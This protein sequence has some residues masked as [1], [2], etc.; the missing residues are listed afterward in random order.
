[1]ATNI[2][3]G[4]ED[5]PLNQHLGQMAYLDELPRTKCYVAVG[6]NAGALSFSG[7]GT[8]AF[9]PWGSSAAY[10]YAD[11]GGDWDIANKRFIAPQTGIYQFN[12][13]GRFS[14]YG[15]AT[16][17]YIYFTAYNSTYRGGG[18]RILLWSPGVD[19]GGTYR[20]HN[21]SGTVLMYAGDNV[22]P[23]VR[24][25]HSNSG[26]I[27]LDSSSTGQADTYFDIYRVG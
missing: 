6:A 16:I 25:S 26:S 23:T 11:I 3:T 22:T 27:T 8:T 20:P 18:Q 7:S 15:S 10:V 13:G 4:P 19:S 2:G 24:V 5:I 9:T 21:F 17:S 1:M 12:M 14:S